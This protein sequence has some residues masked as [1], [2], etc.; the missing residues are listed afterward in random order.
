MWSVTLS[1][2][3]V[4]TFGFVKEQDC[5]QVTKELVVVSNLLLLSMT[6]PMDCVTASVTEAVDCVT[7]TIDCVTE[8]VGCVTVITGCVTEAVSCVTVTI[9]CVTVSIG[10]VTV[11][12]LSF[13]AL[14]GCGCSMLWS[15]ATKSID[16]VP[17]FTVLVKLSLQELVSACDDGTNPCTSLSIGA[18]VCLLLAILTSK[19]FFC[20]FFD[21][22]DVI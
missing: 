21:D 2:L 22:K 6:A 9:G 11:S 17:D 4:V 16:L 19:F 8:A 5:V 20:D 10:L 12:M 13:T 3:C 7:K 15:L 14:P 18:H 1:F